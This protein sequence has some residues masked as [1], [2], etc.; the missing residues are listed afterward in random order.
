ML[1]WFGRVCFGGEN[2]KLELNVGEK[3]SD[4]AIAF[5][6]TSE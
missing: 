2:V 3:L 1:A 5:V 6:H 4:R